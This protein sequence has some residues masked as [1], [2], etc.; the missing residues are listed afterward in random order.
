LVL[1]DL[2]VSIQD[3]GAV[4]EFVGAIAVLVSL[5]YL[6]LQ[7]REAKKTF[8]TG[9]QLQIGN[10]IQQPLRDLST[11][12]ELYDIWLRGVDDY[13]GLSR[14]EKGR[15][16]LVLKALFTAYASGF[17][18]AQHDPVILDRIEPGVDW[19]V[20]L[21]GVRDWWLKAGRKSSSV[22]WRD[23][24]DSRLERATHNLENTAE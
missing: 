7:V 16:A 22:P 5:L 19:W 24:V 3:L 23:Y 4:G 6:A 13:H 12:A 14:K 8:N 10:A 1:G 15:F 17:Y 18:A 21:K 20:S 9:V 11:D 2:P